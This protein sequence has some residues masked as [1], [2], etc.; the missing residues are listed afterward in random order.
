MTVMEFFG[1][2]MIAF[3]PPFAMFCLSIAKDPIRII[4]LISAAFFWLL[5][6]LLSSIVWFLVVPL[7]SHLI[8]GVICSVIFQEAFRYLFYKV[9]RNAESGLQKVSE[10]GVKG[11][12][13][14]INRLSLA[15]V[16]GLGFG[17][18]SGAFS[19]INVLADAVGPGTVGIRG[20]SPNFFMVSAFTTLAFILLHTGWGVI[21]YQALDAKNYPLVSYVVLSHL[22][23]SCIS[24]VNG[25]QLYAVSLL[26]TYAT[27]VFTLVLAFKVAG[28]TGETL[29][30]VCTRRQ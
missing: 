2:G 24:L 11:P 21:F 7:R 6:L 22:A 10:V 4:I 13:F 26:A 29:K 27:T 23:V 18:I 30:S 3:G 14:A 15:Y 28:G 17:V 25:S 19:I 16:A 1:C 5:S 8:F 12:A 9:L 20:D